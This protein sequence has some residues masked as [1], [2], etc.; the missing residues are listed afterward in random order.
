MG[1]RFIKL[2]EGLSK[3]I[4]DPDFRRFIELVFD[5]KF[6]EEPVYE[7]K[8]GIA[9][10]RGQLVT[11]LQALAEKWNITKDAAR[12]QLQRFVKMRLIKTEV[13]YRQ[14]NEGEE[15][16]PEYYNGRRRTVVTIIDFDHYSG[17]GPRTQQNAHENAH[18]RAHN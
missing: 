6:T 17:R 16:R 2:P 18:N 15:Y 1:S 3:R 12:C 10:T 14:I 9:I 4:P 8:G 13:Q 5:A 11:T 7:D